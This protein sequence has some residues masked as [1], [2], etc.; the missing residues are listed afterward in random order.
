MK[1]WQAIETAPLDGQAILAMRNDWPGCPGGV[2]SECNGHNTYVVEWWGEEG[3]GEWVCYMD[4]VLDPRCPVEPTH[5]MP[6]PNPPGP[7]DGSET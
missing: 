4:M 5:W 7:V 1:N 2:A 3:E 6:L